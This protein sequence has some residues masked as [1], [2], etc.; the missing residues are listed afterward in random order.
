M[1]SRNRLR[2]IDWAGGG[3]AFLRVSTKERLT[4]EK[5][6]SAVEEET[7]QYSRIPKKNGNQGR[8]ES[9]QEPTQE[10]PENPH[11]LRDDLPIARAM[12]R[13]SLR[14]RLKKKEEISFI[15][16]NGQEWR[17][18]QFS[19]Y[20]LANTKEQNRFAV[21]VGR[22]SGTATI[23]NRIKRRIREIVRANDW[24]GPPCFD[25]LV[26]PQRIAAASFLELNNRYQQWKKSV[27]GL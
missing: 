13:F 11:G 2:R 18:P 20:S 23:R 4:D 1:A 21:L 22:R 14:K 24:Q 6:V 19:V 10:R 9:Y 17:S 3:K 26:I 16:R 12:R 8:T 7:R 15:R 27:S 25:I 5:N